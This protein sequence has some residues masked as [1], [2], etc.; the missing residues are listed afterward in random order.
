MLRPGDGTEQLNQRVV[1]SCNEIINTAENALQKF[2]NLKNVTIIPH[3]PRY[4]DSLSDPLNLKPSLAKYANEYMLQ[5][6]TGRKVL[7]L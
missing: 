5:V 6:A 2:N 7:V 3:G 4:D 1:K